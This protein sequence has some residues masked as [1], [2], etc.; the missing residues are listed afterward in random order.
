MTNV[1]YS[2][3]TVLKMGGEKLVVMRPHRACKSVGDI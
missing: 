1:S 3:L 2:D